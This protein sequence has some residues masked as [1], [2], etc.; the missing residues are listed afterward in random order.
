MEPILYDAPISH[1]PC[2]C[3]HFHRGG[4]V[5]SIRRGGVIELAVLY[6]GIVLLLLGTL[7]TIY[8][9]VTIDS[10]ESEVK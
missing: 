5:Y 6:G 8:W 4:H 10:R 7:F 1:W 2:S 9:I 3:R